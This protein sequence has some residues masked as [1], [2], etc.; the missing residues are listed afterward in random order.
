MWAD[1][2]LGAT[3]RTRDRGPLASFLLPPRR[4]SI[5][6]LVSLVTLVVGLLPASRA[7][8]Q[9][10]PGPPQTAASAPSDAA[11]ASTAP[12]RSAPPRASPYRLS[13]AQRSALE[14][15]G[16][17]YDAED[18]RT[19]ESMAARGFSADELV[20][21]SVAVAEAGHDRSRVEEAATYLA[22]GLEPERLGLFLASGDSVTSS[23]NRRRIGGHALMATGWTL[24]AVGT[25][26]STLGALGLPSALG[27]SRSCAQRDHQG[28]LFACYGEELAVDLLAG[29]VA[30]G[31]GAL[32]AGIPTAIVGTLRRSRWL[33][34]GELARE[35]AAELRGRAQAAGRWGHPTFPQVALVPVVGQAGGGLV[36]ALT[37]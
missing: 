15:S 6:C 7:R 20:T 16:Y 2:Q 22:V 1:L 21:A 30:F 11:A 33:P 31:L 4:M 10:D 34:R 14:S 29:T 26:F 19:A 32:V 24:A 28:E 3:Q 17:R 9:D 35:S 13:E 36:L 25:L 23:Y 37:L 12:G 18:L 27:E 8:A 5:R